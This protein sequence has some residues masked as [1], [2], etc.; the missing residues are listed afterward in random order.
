MVHDVGV[1]DDGLGGD[2]MV[3][4]VVRQ[5]EVEA[6][7]ACL[8]GRDEGAGEPDGEVQHVCEHTSALVVTIPTERQYCS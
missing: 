3:L 7:V 2:Q 1:V 4:L 8:L 6:K 5:P